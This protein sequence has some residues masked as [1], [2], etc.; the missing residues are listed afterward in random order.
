MLPMFGNIGVVFDF[1]SFCSRTFAS[2][3]CTLREVGVLLQ[4]KRL[5]FR[6]ETLHFESCMCVAMS[7]NVVYVLVKTG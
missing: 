1:S 4:K 6:A 3:P 7:V 2:I 5:L